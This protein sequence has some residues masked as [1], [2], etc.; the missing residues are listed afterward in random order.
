MDGA[1]IG[2]VARFQEAD[3]KKDIVPFFKRNGSTWAAGI[4]LNPRPLFGLDKLATHPKDKAVFIVEGE[5]SAAALQSIGIAAVSSLGGSQA[6]KQADWTP[7]SGY[8]L[9]YLLPD[10]D[11]PGEHY[12]QDVYR[13]LMALESPPPC[14]VVVLSGLPVA[15][16]VVDWIQSLISDWNGYT[17]I[18]KRL[19]EPLREEL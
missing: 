3:G 15:G 18:D 19:Y 6:A 7:L 5:K 1:T 12:M 8:K 14:K 17:P 2:I 16:D 4:E 11:E 13:A 9:V 10:A